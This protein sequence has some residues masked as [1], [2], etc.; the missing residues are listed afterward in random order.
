MQTRSLRT[1]IQI[2]RDGSFAAAAKQLN[3]TLSAVSMQ[4]KTL[5]AQL[6]VQLFDRKHRPPQLTPIGRVICGHAQTLLTAEAALRAACHH[7]S[8]SSDPLSGRFR[9]GFV[10]TASIR[11]L[12][13]F[14]ARAQS[15]APR[16]QFDIETGTSAQL[17]GRVS[18]GQLDA[19]VVTASTTPPKG[20]TYTALHQERMVLASPISAP[21]G[22][23]GDLFRA[24]PFYHFQA[25]SG[26]G[27]L[28]ATFVAPHMHAESR[29]IYLDSVE[30]IMECVNRGLGFTLLPEPDVRRALIS[31]TRIHP[32]AG[33]VVSRTIA[34]ATPQTAP[35]PQTQRLATVLGQS[36][37]S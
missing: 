19:A 37:P 1:L 17:E 8:D 11:L 10:A 4:M 30:A 2:A 20:L 27:K 16:A 31:N 12:P 18:A 9:I 3:M 32:P 21:E 28:I 5:E 34:L 36:V 29:V 15:D 24:L 6:D 25:G 23:L 35:V 33:P 22:G 26:I 7:A 13:D 14:L